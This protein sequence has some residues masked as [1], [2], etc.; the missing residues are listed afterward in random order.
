MEGLK[1]AKIFGQLGILILVLVLIYLV[2]KIFG[3]VHSVSLEKVL[4]GV[5]LGQLF[6]VGYTY[7]AIEEVKD[8]KKRVEKI[9]KKLKI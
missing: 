6:Y 8:L 2:L 3:V 4:V 1:I 5:V 7:R 9:E